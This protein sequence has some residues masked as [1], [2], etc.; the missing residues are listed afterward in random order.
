MKSRFSLVV[1]FL[2][3]I[4][5]I[6]QLLALIIAI[7]LP[8]KID[9]KA[10]VEIKKPDMEIQQLAIYY[11]LSHGNICIAIIL[12]VLM[13]TMFHKINVNKVL[14]KGNRYHR[15]TMFEYWLYSHVLGYVKC[16]LIRVPVS[17]QF[18]L[19]LSDMFS[20]YVLDKSEKSSDSEKITVRK[21]GTP[22]YSD[23][24][25]PNALS[26]NSTIKLETDIVYIAISDTYP[27]KDTMLP[28]KCNK[29]NTVIIQREVN[30]EDNTRCES[31]AL[32][33]KVLNVIKN[34]DRE[35]VVN[36]LAT[37]N[38]INTSKIV[39]EVFKTGGQDNIKHL[40]VY[41]QPHKTKD[42][43]NF[44]KKGTKIF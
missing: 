5:Q 14:N 26:N 29:N 20:E 22:S 9:F 27:I 25:Q 24:L 18:K 42:D 23:L 16:S 35:V 8:F 6:I 38:T 1:W 17:D 34:I 11:A 40:Y 44:S 7:L 15:R 2:D 19:I 3:S 32:I 4:E 33:A 37:T 28:D 12:A 36:I 31:K 10:I 43:W 41:S 30:K 39:N 13:I 21:Y